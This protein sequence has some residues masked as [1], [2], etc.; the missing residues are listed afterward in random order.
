MHL[1]IVTAVRNGFSR[2]ME[3]AIA[4]HV[5]ADTEVI[6]WGQRRLL[7]AGDNVRIAY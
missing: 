2:I 6:H 5:L 4:A 1:I 7:R 3:H